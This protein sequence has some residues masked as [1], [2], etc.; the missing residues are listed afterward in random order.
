MNPEKSIPE[1]TEKADKLFSEYIRK[2]D[3]DETGFVACCTCDVMF[4]WQ[5]LDCGH[6][7][8]RS[9]FAIRYDE[10]NA[11]PQCKPC[12]SKHNDNSKPYAMFMLKKYKGGTLTELN[13]LAESFT[14]SL[15]KRI[16]LNDVIKKYG[17]RKKV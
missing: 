11:H 12:N 9:K 17:K 10:R 4:R 13:K 15:D 7:I 14:S 3:A 8:S 2:K 1:L 16:I 6:F 5:D